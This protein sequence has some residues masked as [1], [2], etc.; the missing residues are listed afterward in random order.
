M[1][2]TLYCR[3]IIHRCFLAKLVKSVFCDA[4]C[5]DFHV[6]VKVLHDA[7]VER[8][9]SSLLSQYQQLLCLVARQQ[10]LC[11]K[12]EPSWGGLVCQSARPTGGVIVNV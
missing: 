6:E 9:V 12:T 3:H 2:E 4:V 8:C 5:S 1:L 10:H 11:T 7:C